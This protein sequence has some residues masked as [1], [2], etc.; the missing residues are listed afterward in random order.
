MPRNVFCFPGLWSY[1]SDPVYCL[2]A[3]LLLLLFRLSVWLCHIFYYCFKNEKPDLGFVSHLFHVLI[4]VNFSWTCSE[5]ISGIS[6]L[7]KHNNTCFWIYRLFARL[8]LVRFFVH[9]SCLTEDGFRKAFERFFE[10]NGNGEYLHK[11]YPK[12]ALKTNNGS[13]RYRRTL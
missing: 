4:V 9:H 5:L 6:R 2:I 1:C 13:P 12:Y 11:K 7:E 10:E 3:F 8:A